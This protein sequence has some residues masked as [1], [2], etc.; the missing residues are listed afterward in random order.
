MRHASGR[1]DFTR[2]ECTKLIPRSSGDGMGHLP[3]PKPL[4][5]RIAPRSALDRQ[6]V[7]FAH[8]PCQS[9]N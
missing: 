8:F 3:I 6:V 9:T 1:S 4:I 7:R 2:S 5:P